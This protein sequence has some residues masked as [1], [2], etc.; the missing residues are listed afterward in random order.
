MDAPL[1]T[2]NGLSASAPM[3]IEWSQRFRIFT[4]YSKSLKFT[5]LHPYFLCKQISIASSKKFASA[6]STLIKH[7]YWS[8]CEQLYLKLKILPQLTHHLWYLA[9]KTCEHCQGKPRPWWNRIF[10]TEQWCNEFRRVLCFRIKFSYCDNSFDLSKMLPR[11]RTPSPSACCGNGCS[12]CVMDLHDQ[13]GFVFAFVFLPMW[14]IY[15]SRLH[16]YDVHV[17]DDY[18]LGSYF[19]PNDILQ[20]KKVV[21]KYSYLDDYLQKIWTEPRFGKNGSIKQKN[22]NKDQED[23]CSICVV[24]W[25]YFNCII[26]F[27]FAVVK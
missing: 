20:H 21:R 7:Y 8:W 2:T 15:T 27:V 26:V 17:L 23:N 22:S 13:V 5:R 1:K 19:C 18:E 25:V 3:E 10:I 6:G 12:P 4:T 14:W 11:P 16:L 24:C 9:S